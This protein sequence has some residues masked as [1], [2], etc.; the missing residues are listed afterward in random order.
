MLGRT[1]RSKKGLMRTNGIAGRY[2]R[3]NH[4]EEETARN[5]NKYKE[6]GKQ[7]I[8]KCEI[9]KQNICLDINN[10]TE[11]S[12]TRGEHLSFTAIR[13]DQKWRTWREDRSSSNIAHSDAGRP[14]L[15][16]V[17]HGIFGNMNF[18]RQRGDK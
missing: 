13:N 16:N 11:M 15:R 14:E 2:G 6:N 3:E 18:T 1:R 4:F 17:P 7:I 5:Y 9:L 12:T 10:L 8:R